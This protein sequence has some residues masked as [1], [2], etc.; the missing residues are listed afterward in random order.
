MDSKTAFKR[1][2]LENSFSTAPDDMYRYDH[3]AQVAIRESMPWKKDPHYFTH[4]KV[5]GI[6]LVKMMMHAREGLQKIPGQGEDY[7]VMGLLQGKIEANTLIVL[8]VFGVLKGNEVRVTAGAADIEYMCQYV[9]TSEKVG[10]NDSVIGWY[11]SHPG[12][13]CW[14]SGIDVNTQFNNQNFQDPYLAIVVDPKRTLSSGKVE[15][16]AFR[17]W[18]TENY[19]IPEQ[20][21]MKVPKGK[22]EFE[23]GV[24]SHRYY[25]LKISVFQSS[26]DQLLLQQLWSKY[27]VKTLSISRNL[28]NC[29]FDAEQLVQLEDNIKDAEKELEKHKNQISKSKD[30]P[31][32]A[33][34]AKECS[35]AAGE[36]LNGVFSQV[37]KHQLF[38][39]H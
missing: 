25:E 22:G 9:A 34:V 11:H 10:K 13:G 31:Q 23:F 37:V 19:V 15:I 20:H 1:F 38:N 12:F 32:I 3:E 33:V 39:I 16:K 18:P 8:D 30:E 5:S 26:L 29:E 2:E 36:Q 35:A 28:L 14:L 7:E 24:Y 4:V 21:K 27:W 6:A 17:T